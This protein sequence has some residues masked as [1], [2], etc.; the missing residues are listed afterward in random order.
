MAS[1]DP[2]VRDLGH[3]AGPAALAYLKT[4]EDG[5][6]LV[7]AG[8]DGRVRVWD[9]EGKLLRQADDLDVD[10]AVFSL[11][12]APS[13][14]YMAAGNENSVAVRPLILGSPELLVHREDCTYSSEAYAMRGTR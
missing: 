14:A 4:A 10:G 12:V 13:G 8:P 11:A 2:S 6:Q 1:S 9:S 5:V 3:G 7:T